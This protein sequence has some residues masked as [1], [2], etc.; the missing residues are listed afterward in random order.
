M[1]IPGLDK[2]AEAE[3]L[4]IP[5]KAFDDVAVTVVPFRVEVTSA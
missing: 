3:K 1:S 4:P 2:V 5:M